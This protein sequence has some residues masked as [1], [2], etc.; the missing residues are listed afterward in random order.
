MRQPVVAQAIAAQVAAGER[1]IVGVMLESFLVDGRQE[2]G[3]PADA[4]LRPEHHRRLHGLGD[5]R[6]R[7]WPSW[8][9]PCAAAA[10]PRPKHCPA[11]VR[12]LP[13][14]LPAAHRRSLL[15]DHALLG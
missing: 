11:P 9:P 5:H 8:P 3:D 4:D 10:R 13:P 1:G 15:G 2:L 14:H 6:A 12:G 7:C